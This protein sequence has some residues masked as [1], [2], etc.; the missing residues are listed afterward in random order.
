[1]LSFG[2]YEADLDSH[3]EYTQ[4]VSSC[5]L[6]EIGYLIRKS[7]FILNRYFVNMTPTCNRIWKSSIWTDINGDWNYNSTL[8]KFFKTRIIKPVYFK[9]FGK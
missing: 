6:V 9:L 2:A 5:A 7:L 8:G 3:Q 4:S 1:M